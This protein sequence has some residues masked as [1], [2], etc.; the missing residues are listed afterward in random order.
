VLSLAAAYRRQDVLAALERAVQ[1]GAFSL[2]AIQR[3]L[4]ARSQP[5]TPLDLL[6]DS[7]R[8][9]LD[10]LLDRKPTPPRP[11]S[12]YQALLGQ[13]PQDGEPTDLPES[14]NCAD[15]KPGD[16][17]EGDDPAQLA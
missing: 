10:N 2:T 6:S 15:T 8:T 4:A 12:D 16:E 13:G 3:I 7:H 11:T 1:Y 14:T 17:D 9:Y 5:K